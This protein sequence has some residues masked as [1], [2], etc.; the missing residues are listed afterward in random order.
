MVKASVNN[1]HEKRISNIF[2]GMVRVIDIG[3][4][5]SKN[6]P[7]AYNDSD[8]DALSKDWRQVGDDFRAAIKEYEC[9]R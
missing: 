1:R 3:A 6:S 9:V 8:L 5:I 7:L 4:T 2:R